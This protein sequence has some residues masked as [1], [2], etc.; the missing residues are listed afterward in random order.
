MKRARIEPRGSVGL[1]VAARGAEKATAGLATGL[2]STGAT[3]VTAAT[4]PASTWTVDVVAFHAVGTR[5][6]PPRLR[7]RAA[8][9]VLSAAE[10]PGPAEELSAA[11]GPELQRPRLRDLPRNRVSNDA[12][13]LVVETTTT[14]SLAEL[15]QRVERL[16]RRD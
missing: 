3:A 5:G 12:V 6:P 13:A 10:Q 8:A 4:D 9:W 7:S 2:V 11:E 16:L 14:P 15:V 1:E